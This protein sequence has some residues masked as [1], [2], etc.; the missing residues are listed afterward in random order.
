MCRSWSKGG[1]GLIC[2]IRGGGVLYITRRRMGSVFFFFSLLFLF[3]YPSKF[4]FLS[5]KPQ[6]QNREKKPLQ[7]SYLSERVPLSVTTKANSPSILSPE[8]TAPS[9]W[10]LTQVVPQPSFP[11]QSGQN[12]THKH[13]P[14]RLCFWETFR[15][16]L[17][18]QLQIQ[19]G[20]GITNHTPKAALAL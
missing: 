17:P 18:L 1:V 4:S 12:P 15:M 14:P 16:F 10:C 9:G 11:N 2:V 8:K 3:C 5:P 6:K 13:R 19:W 7:S 20:R